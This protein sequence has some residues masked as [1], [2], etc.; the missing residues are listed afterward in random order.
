[1]G[2]EKP[3]GFETKET[4]HARVADVEGIEATPAQYEVPVVEVEVTETTTVEPAPD[5]QSGR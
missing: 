1:M 4:G 5:N 2:A 3:A